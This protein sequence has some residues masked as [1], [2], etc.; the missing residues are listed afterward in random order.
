MSKKKAYAL[1]L[2]VGQEEY[3]GTG[4]TPEEAIDNLKLPMKPMAKGDLTFSHDG[5]SKSMFVSPIQ[6]K[7]LPMKVSRILLVKQF[8]FGLK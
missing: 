7:R 2:K 3:V 6:I 4:D 1:T 5:K 8:T